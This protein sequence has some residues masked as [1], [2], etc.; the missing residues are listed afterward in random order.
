MQHLA[1]SPHRP[2]GGMA[3]PT[4]PTTDT[5]SSDDPCDRVIDSEA[6]VIRRGCVEDGPPLDNLIYIEAAVPVDIHDIK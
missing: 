2:P 4:V 6:E 3:R 1:L 5:G